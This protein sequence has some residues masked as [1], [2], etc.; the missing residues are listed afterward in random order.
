LYHGIFVTP[1]HIKSSG[2]PQSSKILVSCSGC[3]KA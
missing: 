2:V 1:G 3:R